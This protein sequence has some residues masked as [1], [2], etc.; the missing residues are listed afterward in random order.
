MSNFELD[1]LIVRVDESDYE[2]WFVP[3]GDAIAHNI[4]NG[5]IAGTFPTL[6]EAEAAIRALGHIVQNTAKGDAS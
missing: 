2:V 3:V 1:A 4:I 6:T 5:F